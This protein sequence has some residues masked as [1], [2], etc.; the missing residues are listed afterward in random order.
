[1]DIEQTNALGAAMF[2]ATAAGF[3]EKKEDSMNEM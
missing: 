2:A 1:M 3:Y